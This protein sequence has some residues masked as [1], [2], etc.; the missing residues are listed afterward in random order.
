RLASRMS[1]DGNASDLQRVLFDSLR[2]PE[3]LQ[4]QLEEPV[5]TATASVVRGLRLLHLDFDS[6]P[7]QALGHA[8]ALAKEVVNAGNDQDAQSLWQ[9]LLNIAA[10]QRES[11]GAVDLHKLLSQPHLP[12]LREHPDLQRDWDQLA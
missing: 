3:I 5:V 6:E 1:E 8:L 2:C 10:T 11:G 7:S 4:N 12:A 9:A